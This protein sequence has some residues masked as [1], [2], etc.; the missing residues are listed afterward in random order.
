[1]GRYPPQ[2]VKA[3]PSCTRTIFGASSAV[4]SFFFHGSACISG[5]RTM[6]HVFF[7]CSPCLQSFRVVYVNWVPS[8][9]P[10]PMSVQG[11][12]PPPFS[13]CVFSTLYFSPRPPFLFVFPLRFLTVSASLRPLTGFFTILFP[14]RLQGPPPPAFRTM[15]CFSLREFF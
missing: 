10:P 8:T 3:N 4:L 1:M 2:C 12:R 15:N 9:F 5:V 7:H 13:R 14:C 11:R 6:T